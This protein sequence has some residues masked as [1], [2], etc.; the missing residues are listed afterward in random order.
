[1]QIAVNKYK[2][3]PNVKFLFVDTWETAADYVTGVKK[4]ISDNKYTFH[5]LIDDKLET[6]RQA[7][8][9]SAYGVTGIPTKFVID[10]NGH[11]RFKYVGYSGSSDR[12]AD[13]VS[14]MLELTANAGSPKVAT[15]ADMST[16][17][18]SK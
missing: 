3:N 5:V 18:K 6:G 7:K 8:V 10:K 17:E 12:V 1:M 11:I 4:F 14:N 15:K 2:N 16:K 9:V 13:E